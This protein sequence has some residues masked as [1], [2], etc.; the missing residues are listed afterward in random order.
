MK[1]GIIGTGSMGGMLAKSLVAYNVVKSHN[2]RLCNRTKDKAAK[3]AQEISGATVDTRASATVSQSDLVFLCVRPAQFESIVKEI[4][5]VASSDQIFISITSPVPLHQ[6]ESRL[7][8]RVVRAIPSITN[9]SGS[10]GMLLTFGKDFSAVEKEWFTAW[11]QQISRPTE[12]TDDITRIASDFVSCGPAFLAYFLKEWTE[13]AVKETSISYTE[14]ERLITTMM[15]GL[16]KLL[17]KEIYDLQTLQDK[18]CVPGGVTGEGIEALQPYVEGM[19]DELI[20]TTQAKY[21][22][23]VRNVNE[24]FN[25]A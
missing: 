3:L 7:P 25:G 4:A 17:E 20:Q 13:A 22:E 1:V 5:P 8:G 12:I 15:I 14:A 19:F 23:D 6:L 10:G 21:Q 16:G 9:A 24:S 11:F 2:L 18:V